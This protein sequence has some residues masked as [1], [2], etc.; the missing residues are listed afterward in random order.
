MKSGTCTAIIDIIGQ[1][2]FLRIS[3]KRNP[4]YNI[5]ITCI[6]GLSQMVPVARAANKK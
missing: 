4:L 2:I 5:L 1:I 6:K 3:I